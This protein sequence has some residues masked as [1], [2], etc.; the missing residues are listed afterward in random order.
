MALLV[1]ACA[2]AVAADAPTHFDYALDEQTELT[3]EPRGD[4]AKTWAMDL[5]RYGSAERGMVLR[6]MDDLEEVSPGVYVY[7]ARNKEE[8]IDE[9]VR[10]TGQPGSARALAVVTRGLK[11]RSGTAVKVEGEFK[12]IAAAERLA[13]AKLR[14]EK[15]DAVP[16]LVLRP[17]V[18]T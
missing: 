3:L 18:T 7:V 1:F 10:I 9:N 2:T 14:W 17:R 6:Y 12:V 8:G 15:A 4:G 13:R 5:R 11:T 16:L